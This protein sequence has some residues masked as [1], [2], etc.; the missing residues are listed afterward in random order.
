LAETN[1]DTI[2]V[3]LLCANSHKQDLSIYDE[4]FAEDSLFNG[5]VMG[6]E[7][8]KSYSLA[9]TKAFPDRRIKIES[10]VGANGMVGLRW[11]MTGTHLGTFNTAFAGPLEPT[12]KAVQIWGVDYYE[13]RAGK[14][15]SLWSAVDRY[16]WLQ[17]MGLLPV[18][19]AEG[20]K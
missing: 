12:G 5:R 7:A 14:I 1:D 19:P 18:P 16:A 15:T 9:T 3:R 13:V 10:I 8:M 4:I 6:P 2:P 17:Q 11:T 20:R